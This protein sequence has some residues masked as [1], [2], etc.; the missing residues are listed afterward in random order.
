MTIV[1][2]SA[3]LTA[4]A[5]PA[6]GAKPARKQPAPAYEPLGV[7]DGAMHYTITVP[8]NWRE[9]PG[10]FLSEQN[11]VVKFMRQGEQPNFVRGFV[12]V[13]R[14]SI[15]RAYILVQ[16]KAGRVGAS[17]ITD[18]ENSIASLDPEE[19]SREGQEIVKNY[20]TDVS[21]GRPSFDRSTGR[22]AMPGR[23]T[24]PDGTTVQSMSHGSISAGGVVIVHCYTSAADFSALAP[25]FQTIGNSVAFDAG[26]GYDVAL[27]QSGSRGPFDDILKYGLIGGATGLAAALFGKLRN[28][29][30]G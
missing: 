20:A 15:V 6:T 10:D 11:R 23:M 18:I 2:G 22:F 19:L 16:N 13:D 12:L 17:D 8:G 21:I 27:A 7:H 28:K 3:G 1:L 9:M 5:Q 29:P 25:T 4:H 24:L 30:V 26:H 14:D